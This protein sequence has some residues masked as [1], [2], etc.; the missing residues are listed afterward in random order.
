[1][2]A[3][4]SRYGDQI[5]R[6]L[7]VFPPERFLFLDF[8]VLTADPAATVR[9]TCAFL[10]ID[11]P[12]LDLSGAEAE[13]HP[14]YRLTP[15]GQAIHR[16]R[17]SLPWAAGALRAVLPGRLTGFLREKVAKAPAEI[18]LTHE[19]EAAALFAEDRARVLA[20]TGLA[21]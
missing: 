8:R 13:K 6:Y 20:L 9:Q 16:L 3:L 10:G 19:A 14:A 4:A 17:K 5:E 21:I 2:L 18:V 7:A 15:A 1:M 12:A 11:P